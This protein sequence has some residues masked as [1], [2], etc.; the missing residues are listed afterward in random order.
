MESHFNNNPVKVLILSKDPSFFRVDGSIG[1]TLQRHVYYFELLSE[2]VPASELRVVTYTKRGMELQHFSPMH[3]MEIYGTNSINR[4]AYIFDSLRIVKKFLNEGW[5]PDVV[6]TQEPFEDG[7][8]GDFISRFYGAKFI[9]QI[10]FD[11]FSEHWLKERFFNR[12]RLFLARMALSAASSI[13]V[14]NQDL[15]NKLQARLS[16]PAEKIAVIPVAV[17]FI[18]SKI[19]KK[20]ARSELKVDD[21]FQKIV[22]YVGSIYPPKN[23]FLWLDVARL[24]SNSVND[25][26][27]VVAGDGPQLEEAINYSKQLGIDNRV[28]FIGGIK[29]ERI[30][31]VFRAANVLLLTSSNEG[32]GRVIIEA[33]LSG[34]P[35]VSTGCAG[36][37]EIISDGVTGFV[38]PMDDA[39]SLS[40]RVIEI[41]QDPQKMKLLGENAKKN[42]QEKYNAE[43]QARSIV[44]H[45]ISQC[46]Y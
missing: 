29:Y 30:P 8:L 31:A 44:D 5:K 38:C 26:Y 19:D 40:S 28:K 37:S 36:P 2:R 23:I 32:F 35:V 39:N 18:E 13:R 46:I 41:L 14:V 34:I 33:N 1:N 17:N 10:H 22:L 25:S 15:K 21:S 11:L 16:V 27:F 12:V 9:P 45:W 7:N 3:G 4:A 6:T 24:V 20:Q 43:T 42:A